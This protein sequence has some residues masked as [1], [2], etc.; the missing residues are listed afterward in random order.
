MRPKKR[1]KKVQNSLE[2]V[3]GDE[4]EPCSGH[5]VPKP[6]IIEPHL[7][8]NS[9][10]AVYNPS[11][12]PSDL[13]T[14][15]G[16]GD[17]G[18]HDKMELN[19]SKSILKGSAEFPKEYQTCTSPCENPESGTT[20]GDFIEANSGNCINN[21]GKNSKRYCGRK[22]SAKDSLKQH[23]GKSML[24]ASITDGEAVSCTIARNTISKKGGKKI[25]KQNRMIRSAETAEDELVKNKVSKPGSL[26]SSVHTLESREDE[27]NIT[28]ACFLHNRSK[29]QFENT[30]N[31]TQTSL[32]STTSSSN[33]LLRMHEVE[34][35]VPSIEQDGMSQTCGAGGTPFLLPASTQP[36]NSNTEISQTW[37]I[38]ANEPEGKDRVVDQKVGARGE[39]RNSE[40]VNMLSDHDDGDKTLASLLLKKSKK[41]GRAA[42]RTHSGFSSSMKKG[43]LLLPEVHKSHDGNQETSVMQGRES[44]GGCNDVT[45]GTSLDRNHSCIL[46]NMS[47]T[48][49]D[50][51]LASFLKKK[52]RRLRRAAKGGTRLSHEAAK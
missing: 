28:L 25:G 12:S 47:T 37:R 15:N 20:N 19:D 41:Y 13:S 7:G 9:L 24:S 2:E 31:L 42:K 10:E 39:A 27:D 46:E 3:Q 14:T 4:V 43:S 6:K 50:I 29:R 16:Q 38:N 21:R 51:T 36:D 34:N 33:S 35:Q 52:G 44:D 11:P 1:A 40:D 17:L 5:D 48:E 49:T 8:D 23:I 22:F 45:P 30:K 18:G 32:H 26:S